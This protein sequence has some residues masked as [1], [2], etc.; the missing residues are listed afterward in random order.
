MH[1]VTLERADGTYLAW[2][3]DLPGCAV[4]ATSRREVLEK[5]PGAI[6]EFVA[7]T[8]RPAA[9][10]EIEVV[11]EVESAIEAEEDTE[12]LVAADRDALT[13]DDSV[14]G[15]RIARQVARRAERVAAPAHR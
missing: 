15:A 1:R 14:L 7:W 2:V 8:G 4:R 5:L 3:D 10:V 6:S 12:V 11:E 9:A 13:E